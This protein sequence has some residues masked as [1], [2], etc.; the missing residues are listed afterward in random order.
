MGEKTL[1]NVRKS[2]L[3]YFSNK[4]FD[5]W[6]YPKS[7]LLSNGM[8]FGISYNKLW[9]FDPQENKIHDVGRIKLNSSINNPTR[10]K[11]NQVNNAFFSSGNPINTIKS[12]S[13]PSV[14]EFGETTRATYGPIN[15]NPA[16]SRN[17]EPIINCFK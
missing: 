8:I 5:E 3:N 9:L 2:F 17:D 12:C 7:F 16:K 13:L 1:K 11:P 6:N 4:D 10:I 14:N 15:P